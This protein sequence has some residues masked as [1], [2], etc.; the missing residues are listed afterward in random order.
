MAAVVR[1]RYLR[2]PLPVFPRCNAVFFLKYP[3]KIGQI[4]KSALCGNIEYRLVAFKESFCRKCQ[5]VIV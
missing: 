4:F 3:V 5:T 2:L 1:S